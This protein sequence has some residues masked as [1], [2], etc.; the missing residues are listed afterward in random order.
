MNE[1]PPSSTNL[2]VFTKLN[3]ASGSSAA[4]VS[5]NNHT[6]TLTECTWEE[7]GAWENPTYAEPLNHKPT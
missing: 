7:S 1:H 3:D 4:D 6:G 5:S 2:K